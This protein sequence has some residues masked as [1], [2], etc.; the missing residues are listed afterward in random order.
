M[1]SIAYLKRKLDAF[2][3]IPSSEYEAL[4]RLLPRPSILEKG[5]ELRFGSVK[6]HKAYLVAEGWACTFAPLPDGSRQII[7]IAV[8]G[9]IVGLRGLML[10]DVSWRGMMLSGSIVYELNPY[11]LVELLETAPRIAAAILWAGSRD[12]AL[13]VERLATIGHRP[14]LE[15]VVCLFLE[16]KARL[17]LIGKSSNGV[18]ACPLKQGQI[19][20]ALALTPVHLSRVL[21]TLRE[22]RILQVR[23]GEVE[24]FDE[25]R[26][27]AMT[28]FDGSYLDQKWVPRDAMTM[29]SQ[30][31]ASPP[32]MRGGMQSL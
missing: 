14:A 30:Y 18:F 6:Q 4:D 2:S 22:M 19:A 15:R 32:G 25:E 10:R 31:M 28:H 21:R 1:Y 11:S 24:I 17:D 20:S 23:D 13:L 27:I 8:P 16:L 26:A 12:E 3:K 5:E 29:T 9:D 7:D